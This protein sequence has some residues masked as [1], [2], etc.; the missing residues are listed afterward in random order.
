MDKIH[1]TEVFVVL[2]ESFTSEIEQRYCETKNESTNMNFYI[3]PTVFIR[4]YLLQVFVKLLI[5]WFIIYLSTYTYFL[6]LYICTELLIKDHK[7]QPKRDHV[8]LVSLRYID[9]VS[10]ILF[11]FLRKVRIGSLMGSRQIQGWENGDKDNIIIWHC[12]L[13]N[14]YKQHTSSESFDVYNTESV[15]FQQVNLLPSLSSVWVQGH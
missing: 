7:S 4:G 13:L 3:K 5:S 6:Y 2:P 12:F 8:E 1:K 9:S 15:R 10:S 14:H 11:D